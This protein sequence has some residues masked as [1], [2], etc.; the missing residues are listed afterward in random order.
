MLDDFSYKFERGCTY[1]LSP[2]E[3][4]KQALL[5][6][7]LVLVA[8]S[9]HGL[10]SPGAKT[11]M[12]FQEEMLKRYG[13]ISCLLYSCTGGKQPTRERIKKRFVG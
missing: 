5:R 1:S 4:V 3:Q 8:D 7:S 13:E 9:G 12:M 11:V 2:L 10:K 6:Y